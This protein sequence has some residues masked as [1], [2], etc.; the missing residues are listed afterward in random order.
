MYVLEV[1]FNAVCVCATAAAHVQSIICS[2]SDRRSGMLRLCFRSHA[3]IDII[4]CPLRCSGVHAAV[5]HIV[6]HCCRYCIWL[7]AQP[8]IHVAHPP[9]AHVF[10]LVVLCSCREIWCCT[11]TLRS[12]WSCIYVA[13]NSTVVLYLCSGVAVVWLVRVW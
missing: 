1:I 3:F 9:R 8:L 13:T 7:K 5:T 2:N 11:A 4:L 10:V 6:V 12:L